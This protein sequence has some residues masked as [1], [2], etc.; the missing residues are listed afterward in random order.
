MKLT[1]EQGAFLRE[2]ELLAAIT[3]RRVTIPILAAVDLAAEGGEV[4]CAATNLDDALTVRCPA[5]VAGA[6][7]SLVTLDTLTGLLQRFPSGECAVEDVKGAVSIQANGSRAQLSTWPADDYPL[8]PAPAEAAGSL[9]ASEV[10]ALIGHVRHAMGASSYYPAGAHCAIDA[11]TVRLAATDSYRVAVASRSMDAT[12]SLSFGLSDRSWN[13]LAKMLKAD[14]ADARVSIAAHENFVWWMTPTRTL[15][16]RRF[17]KD[18]PQY[19]RV[20]PKEFA[21]TVTIQV[22]PLRAA[23]R[24]HL[25]LAT[26]ERTRTDFAVSK[27]H[28]SL[29]SETSRGAAE[30]DVPVEGEAGGPSFIL[31]PRFALDALDALDA[32]HVEWSLSKDGRAVRCRPAD[33]PDAVTTMISTMRP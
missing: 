19:E 29:S 16:C 8:I 32:D 6:G 28:L 17:D 14:A 7:R 10:L 27:G 1:I 22:E 23:L 4:R 20:L 30:D 26:Q 12:V 2:L 18:F 13:A 33:A 15:A 31:N 25:V 9:R 21:F 3:D 11:G 24:R 5:V